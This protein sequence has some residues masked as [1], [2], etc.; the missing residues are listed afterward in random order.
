MYLII[1]IVVIES[2]GFDAKINS[3]THFHSKLIINLRKLK[4][5]RI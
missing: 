1:K 5:Y 4:K 3:I 2:L